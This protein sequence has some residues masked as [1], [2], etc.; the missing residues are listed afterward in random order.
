M[1]FK[2]SMLATL[3]VLVATTSSSVN[4]AAVAG[5]DFWG[6]L[7]EEEY[8]T[9][10]HP[11]AF[12][13]GLKYEANKFSK[14]ENYPTAYHENRHVL[15]GYVGFDWLFARNWKLNGTFGVE[16]KWKRDHHNHDKGIAG[17][18]VEGKLGTV[19]VRG[20]AV[21]AF[22]SLNLTTGGLVIG[23]YIVGGQVKVPVGNWRILLTG[24]SIDDEDY[25]YTRIAGVKKD[26]TYYSLQ[27]VGD[28]GKNL[29]AA[30][31][32]HNME[33]DFRDGL[34]NNGTKKNNTVWSA[35]VD[36]KIA[37]NWTLGGIYA[38][39]NAKIYEAGTGKESS[40]EKKSYAFQL[41][42]GTP[43]SDKVHNTSAWV[44]Y[45]QL[46]STASYTPAYHGVGFGEKGI[47]VGAR[48]NLMKN[49]SLEA[50]YFSG[51][52]ITKFFGDKDS[53]KVHNWYTGIS[54]TF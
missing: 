42:Y 30:V 6:D 38:G 25:D 7:N 4:A 26:S 39:G 27:A 52:K 20:G 3:A 12:Y 22:D 18:Y 28:I 34:F 29:S 14:P 17:G 5:S 13:G 15:T 43:E 49:L 44:A 10:E 48:H 23:S 41:T 8:L 51:E 32:V 24:G 46:G 2:K 31:G 40:D 47:E 9:K 50:V 37:K 54:Y 1:N 35:G 36:Y 33:N 21:P 53:P 16:R 11:F 45:R 19:T